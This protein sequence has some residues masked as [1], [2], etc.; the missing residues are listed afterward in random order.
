MATLHITESELARDVHAVL[1]QVKQ[2][3][4]VVIEQDHRPV[5]ILKSADEQPRTLS[6]MIALAQQ[7]ENERGYRITLGEDFAADM[8]QIVRDRK[9][10]TPRSGE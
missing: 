9:P 2:G 5:A 7:R 3:G 8:E 1:E 4:E 6:Q 10:W